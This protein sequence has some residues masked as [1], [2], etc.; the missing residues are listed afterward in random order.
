MMIYEWIVPSR[1]SKSKGLARNYLRGEGAIALGTKKLSPTAN[2]LAHSNVF[3][4]HKVFEG[5]APM[6]L[7]WYFLRYRH[8]FLNI[9]MG[10]P[11]P[12]WTQVMSLAPSHPQ[13][14]I[15]FMVL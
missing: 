11:P 3:I 10:E 2:C 7:P 12:I 14:H 9:G 5:M 15:P 13:T 1:S 4:S 8:M 6:P